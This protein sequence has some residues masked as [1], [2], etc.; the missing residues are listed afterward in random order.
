VGDLCAKLNDADTFRSVTAERAFLRGMGGGLSTGSGAFAEASGG[1][2]KM[3]ALSFLSAKSRTREALPLIPKNLAAN[4][5]PSYG[6]ASSASQAIESDA[7]WRG[8]LREPV[9]VSPF[10]PE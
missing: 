10:M 5:P 2:I 4:S 8:E 6:G 7:P 9:Q 1:K 3:R